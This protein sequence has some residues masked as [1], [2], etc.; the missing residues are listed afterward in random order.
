MKFL[1]KD[2]FAFTE[3]LGKEG[4][5]EAGESLAPGHTPVTLR[6]NHGKVFTSYGPQEHVMNTI[7]G[8]F[9][10]KARDPKEAID[11]MSHVPGLRLGAVEIRP[12]YD[13]SGHK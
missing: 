11:I 10:I 7:G 2:Y 5:L 13:W 4:K 3:K 6:E 9:V 1:C 8:F 12:V